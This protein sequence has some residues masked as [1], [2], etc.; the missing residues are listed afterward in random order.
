[1]LSKKCSWKD[2]CGKIRHVGGEPTCS[3]L[4]WHIRAAKITLL[5]LKC[6]NRFS[7]CAWVSFKHCSVLLC[8]KSIFVC[9]D[10]GRNQLI[11]SGRG[12]IIVTVIVPNNYTCFMEAIAGLRPWYWLIFLHVSDMLSLNFFVKE[13]FVMQDDVHLCFD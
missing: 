8:I 2:E 5:N 3:F 12:G 11:F 6:L 1:V 10:Q 7:V 9:R 13:M 4:C